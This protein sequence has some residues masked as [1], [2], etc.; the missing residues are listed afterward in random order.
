MKQPEIAP[1]ETPKRKRLSSTARRQ[2]FINQAI[3]FFAEEGFESSTRGLAKKLGV[4]QPLLYRYFPSKDDLISEV[5]DAVYVN[6]WQPEWEP[7]LRDRT[8]PL[9]D[10]LNTFYNVYTDVIFNREWMRIYLFS[11]LKGVDI[12]RRYMQLVRQRILEPILIE[13]RVEL[14]LPDVPAKDCEVEFA[15]IMHGGIFYYGIRD[16]IYDSAI[17][18]DKKRVIEDAIAAFMAGLKIKLKR[19]GQG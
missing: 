7:L 4:T 10:R 19:E 16:L 13:A 11:G 17:S 5:Y 1:D 12:N 2:D 8:R 14:G 3:E 15:W 9:A 18:T 6:R